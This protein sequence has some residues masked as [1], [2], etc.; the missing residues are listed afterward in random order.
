MHMFAVAPAKAA[1]KAAASPT[2]GVYV[3]AGLDRIHERV[4]RSI[5]PGARSKTQLIVL[6][7][8]EKFELGSV[9]FGGHAV[10]DL[11]DTLVTYYVP[12]ADSMLNGLAKFIRDNG[13]EAVCCI[14][15]SKGGFG[16]LMVTRELAAKM[17]KIRF[18]ALAFSPQTMVWPANENLGF[19]SYRKLVRR[20]KR[21]PKVERAM[22]RYGNQR[23]DASLPNLRW[24]VFY[25]AKNDGDRSEAT[26]LSGSSV[27]LEPLPASTH[28]TILPYLC[29][30]AD[31]AEIEALVNKFMSA[32]QRDDDAMTALGGQKHPI[33][34]E[35]LAMP[36]RASLASIVDWALIGRKG[37]ACGQVLMPYLFAALPIFGA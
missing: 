28:T 13:F 33:L 26:A 29:A 2:Q 14:G 9:D 22:N 36:P 3:T 19:G 10:L 11:A 24:S 1:G 30:D 8:R 37:R 20:A 16:S 35:I 18:A 34:D 23:L 4:V 5:R 17:P 25:S 31:E 27:V 7:S 6:S 15:S 32:A 12:F 21:S